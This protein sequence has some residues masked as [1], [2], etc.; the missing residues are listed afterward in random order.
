TGD[1][2]W[3][4]VRPTLVRGSDGEPLFVISAFHDVTALKESERRLSLLADAGS[5]L[6][7]SV[8]YQESL[9]ELAR[10]VV[11]D[12]ADWCVV[13]VVEPERGLRRVAVAHEDP[14]LLELAAAV[15]RRWRS[16]PG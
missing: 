6:G 13:D 9:N 4:L 5:I 3:S 8:D 10:M 7:A 2:R 12:L 11:P 1:E 15:P 14:A 16:T